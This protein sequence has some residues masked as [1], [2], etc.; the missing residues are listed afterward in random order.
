M[1]AKEYLAIVRERE[2]ALTLTT[3]L[4][5]DEIRETKG[6]DAAHQKSHKP[7]RKQL[8][9]AVAVIDELTCDWDPGKHNDRY[10][11]RLKRVVERKRKGKGKG[12]GKGIKPP[13][14]DD[15]Q[16]APSDLMAALERTLEDL[17]V[18]NA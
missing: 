17:R 8:D 1:R 16:P 6:I 3:M 9:A 15:E 2:G 11:A 5:A 10:R 14:T 18:M 7:T 12:K 4:F 13:K